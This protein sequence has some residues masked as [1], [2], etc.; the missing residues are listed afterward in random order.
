MKRTYAFIFARGGSKGVPRKNVRSFA[1]KPLIAHTIELAL[2]I[3]EIAKVIVSTDD[4]EIAEVAARHGAEVPFMRPAELASDHASEWKAW[5]HAVTYVRE[6]MGES[7][8]RFISLPA[9]SPLRSAEDI[10]NLLARFDEG[11]ADL[12][13]GVT[14]SASSPYFNMVKLDGE[15]RAELVNKPEGTVFRRQDAPEVYDI[16]PG[17]YVTT[18]DHVLSSNGVFDGVL[19]TVTIP[20]ER[21][22][23]IDTMLDFDFAEFLFKRRAGLIPS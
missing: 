16:A 5:Q 17:G 15:G 6:T 19:K 10:S 7:F 18:P 8:E 1:G 23:D 13:I 22:V 4:E 21:A 3:P 14:P 11:G 20:S 12:V 2:S 9:T